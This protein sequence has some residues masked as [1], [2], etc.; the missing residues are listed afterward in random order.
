MSRSFRL[1]PRAR[2]DLEEIWRYTAIRWSPKQADR[3]TRDIID[4]AEGLASGA[5]AGQPVDVR[6][7]YQKRRSGSHV[8]YYRFTDETLDVIR[9]LHGRM[10]V[11]RHL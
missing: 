10:D 7:G 11:S 4:A 1:S 5:L 6:D 9:I 2:H 3:Y 8:I